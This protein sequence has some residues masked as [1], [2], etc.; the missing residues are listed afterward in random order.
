M[1]NALNITVGIMLLV[2][3]FAI[4]GIFYTVDETQ[5]VVVTQ[6]GELIGKPKTDAGLYFKWP[7]QTVDYFEKRILEWDGD[8]DEIPTSEKRS[9]LVDITARWRISDVLKF[10]QR[11]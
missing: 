7:W 9:I 11:I 10:M 8:A 5:Q 1:K 3:L 4:S 6:F 2:V